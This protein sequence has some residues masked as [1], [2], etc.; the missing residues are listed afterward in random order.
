MRVLGMLCIALL[1]GCASPD[2]TVAPSSDQPADSWMPSADAHPLYGY[3]TVTTLHEDPARFPQWSLTPEPADA[4]LDAL[5]QLVHLAVPAH[6]LAI[7]GHLL[8]AGGQAGPL[9]IVDLQDPSAAEVVATIDVPARDVATIAYPDGRLVVVTVGGGDQAYAVDVTDPTH[10]MLLAE[11]T[12][13]VTTHNVAVVPG[14]PVV[15][16]A[17][18]GGEITDIWDLST[19]TDPVLLTDTASGPCHDITFFITPEKQRGYCAKYGTHEIWDMADPAN[20]VVL[21]SFDMPID[22][23]RDARIPG[24]LDHTAIVNDDATVLIIGDEAGGGAAPAC[25]GEHHTPVGTRSAL[26]GSLWFYDLTDESSPVLRSWLSAPPTAMDGICTAHFGD[27]IPG[28]NHMTMSWYSAGTTLIDFSDLDHPTT[29]VHVDPSG[30][31]AVAAGDALVPASGL[32]GTWEA[33][34]HQGYVI[35]AEG[36]NGL[37]VFAR[38]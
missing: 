22:L 16:N 27:V 34:E 38:R 13:A 26:H 30:V 1:A 10:P 3:P 20:P 5:E 17:A 7:W 29:K 4:G 32:D 18:F 2:E 25:F 9:H 11:W 15:V 14:S 33:I 23:D 36:V 37:Q 12:T 6:G 24:T 21:G 35:T 31:T 19:P 8:F 28:T